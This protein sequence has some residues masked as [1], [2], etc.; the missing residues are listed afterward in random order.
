MVGRF[1]SEFAMADGGKTLNQFFNRVKQ[2]KETIKNMEAKL[3]AKNG[4]ERLFYMSGAPNLNAMGEMMGVV[5]ILKDI[6]EQRKLE[7][8][9]H[10][11]SRMNAIGRLTGGI[12]HDFNN[13]L[14][15][16]NAY[17]ERLT[18][19]KSD[20]DPELRYLSNI[21]ELIKRATDL[22]GQLLIFSRKADSKL[23][24]IDINAEI[25]KFYE[26][27]I[28]TLPKTID[29]EL[30][31]DEPL[32]TINGDSAQLGQVIMNL[33]VNAKD[34]MPDGGRIRIKT[35]N[36]EFSTATYRRS[37]K[38]EPGRYALFS[39]SDTGCGIS[40][41]NLDHIFEPFFTT[42]EAGKGTG[43]GLSVVYGIVKNHNGFI[44]CT[45]ELGLGTTYEIFFPAT[46]ASV[47]VFEE[48]REPVKATVLSEGQETILL[49]DDEP[50][51]LDIGK[52]LLSLLGYSVLTANSGESALS[53]IHE[54]KGGIAL[55][56]LDLMMPG[57][58]G[59]KCLSEILKIDPD[60]KVLI[61]SGFAASTSQQDLLRAGAVDFIQKP[62]QID[63]LS[64]KIR[65]ILDQPAASS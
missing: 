20:D 29:V 12:A 36:I 50:A 48:R 56:I 34:A 24:P 62:Y 54:Q 16:I 21:K 2:D 14:Q 19:R 5:G 40:K 53:V 31:L 33:T 45:S 60:M 58:G 47:D 37:V 27:L 28:N 64:R 13:I 44:F 22:V 42:K 7:Q 18:M 57:M 35:K 30:D 65:S 51:L 10:H 52:E 17:N 43:I 63:F 32:Q 41:E 9:L 1:F 11:A 39:V 23:E 15:A 8:Q 38:I 25:R 6:T 59:E 61:A 26:L 3:L 4:K 46:A 55:V 49:V